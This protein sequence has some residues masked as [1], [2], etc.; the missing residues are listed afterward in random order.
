MCDSIN[1]KD[2][3]ERSYSANVLQVQFWHHVQSMFRV[4]Y[5]HVITAQQFYARL[6]QIA[7]MN[8]YDLQLVPGVKH[9][10]T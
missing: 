1:Y 8:T 2:L 10:M 9:A 6:L 7:K 4:I 5:S 3:G